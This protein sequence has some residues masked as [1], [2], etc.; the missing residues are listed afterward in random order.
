MAGAMVDSGAGEIGFSSASV[1]KSVMAAMATT[2]RSTCATARL[3][4]AGS[5]AGVVAASV[6]FSAG[7]LWVPGVSSASVVWPAARRLRG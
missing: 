1:E 3:C 7:A 5:S 4:E 2:V 6:S